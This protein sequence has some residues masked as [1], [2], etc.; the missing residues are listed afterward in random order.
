MKLRIDDYPG[1]WQNL[2]LF[3][4]KR[5]KVVAYQRLQDACNQGLIIFPKDLN[6]RAEIEFEETDVEG[7]LSIRYEKVDRRELQTLTEMSLLKEEL[8]GMEK[9]TKQ[10]GTI[11]FDLSAEAKS[12]NKHDDRADV[13]AMAAY[14]LMELRAK[15]ATLMEEKS[16]DFSVLFA[17]YKNKRKDQNNNNPFASRNKSNPFFVGR[18]MF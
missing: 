2:M 16:E 5:D 3:N 17:K 10:N 6:T 9:I 4:F 7:N 15:E 1:A 12:S 14:W 18:R 13:C 8:I 11:Q